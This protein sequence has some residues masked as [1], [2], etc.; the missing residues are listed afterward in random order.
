MEAFGFFALILPSLIG[1]PALYIAFQ[2]SFP[3]FLRII[4]G[5]A[6][7]LLLSVPTYFT[8]VILRG[9]IMEMFR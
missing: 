1:F 2:S 6:G 7:I 3:K 4:M 5:A 9:F 8:G